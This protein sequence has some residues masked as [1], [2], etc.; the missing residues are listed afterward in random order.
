MARCCV[1]ASFLGAVLSV[2]LAFSKR[3]QP[4]LAACAAPWN[5]RAQ[6]QRLREQAI[7]RILIHMGGDSCFVKTAQ[8]ATNSDQF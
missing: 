6:S 7:L 8:N 5:R 2:C 4:Y 1:S 3:S